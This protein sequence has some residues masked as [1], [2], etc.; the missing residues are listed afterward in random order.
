MKYTLIFI[1]ILSIIFP[2]NS[3]FQNVSAEKQKAY[4]YLSAKGE[5]YFSFEFF[6]KG[7]DL[8]KLIL[9]EVNIPAVFTFIN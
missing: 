4:E 2:F 6:D 3:N 7:R 1:F 5:V 8:M 9:T